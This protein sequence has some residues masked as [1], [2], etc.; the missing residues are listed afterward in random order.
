MVTLLSLLT[1]PRCLLPQH[2]G[3]EYESQMPHTQVPK[4][5]HNIDF[6]LFIGVLL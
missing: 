5:I 2:E 6:V 3:P 4:N 1:F